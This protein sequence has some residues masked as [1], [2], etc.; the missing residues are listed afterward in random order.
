MM[1]EKKIS[2]IIPVFNTQDYLEK[3]ISSVLQQTYKNL[4][5]ICID[6]GSTDASG[7]IVD[8]FAKDDKRIKAIHTKNQGESAARN[9]GIM[10]ATGDYIAFLDCDDWIEP[11]MYEELSNLLEKTDADMAIGSW[12]CDVG[13]DSN[14]IMNKKRI[15]KNVFDRNHLL[16]YVYERDSYR[17]FAYMWDKLYKRELF[18]DEV[19]EMLLFDEALPLGGD[20]LFLAKLV[21]NTKKAVY[22]DKA[23]YHYIQRQGSGCRTKDLNKR[24]YGLLAYEMVIDLFE[25]QEIDEIILG[26]VK[27]FLVYHSEIIAKEAFLQK[28][29]EIFSLCK[30]MMKQYEHEYRE[31]NYEHPNRINEY[32]EIL[33]MDIVEGG[34]INEMAE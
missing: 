28:N 4:E 1:D 8:D 23:F 12:Y 20:V 29:H 9:V 24:I 34:N 7:K 18:L 22:L 33:S 31:L 32:E 21:L 5:V 25:K 17:A 15:E 14:A 3:C 13:E 19:G 30:A 6:D 2:V 27:R 26:Y 16:R 11:T 10:E